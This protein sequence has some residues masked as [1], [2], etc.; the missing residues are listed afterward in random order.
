MSQS[1]L[2]ARENFEWMWRSAWNIAV[3]SPL[4]AVRSLAAVTGLR[5]CHAICADKPER[6]LMLAGGPGTPG[7]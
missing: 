3:S 1:L 7:W 6:P 4:L 2:Q 5:S